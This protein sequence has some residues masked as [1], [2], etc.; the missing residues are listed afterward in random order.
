[1][2]INKGPDFWKRDIFIDYP[3]ETV[4]YRCDHAIKKTYVKFY[5]KK[6][7]AEPVQHDNR[8]F[9]DSLLYGD[10]IIEEEYLN[11]KTTAG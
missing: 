11:G 2:P 3:F 1:M 6:E 10:E 7:E 5:N 8:L 4:M 9:N